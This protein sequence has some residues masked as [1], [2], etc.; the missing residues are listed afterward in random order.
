MTE[1]FKKLLF[2]NVFTEEFTELHFNAIKIASDSQTIKNP[3]PPLLK[4][5]GLRFKRNYRKNQ[6]EREKEIKAKK[7]R[8]KD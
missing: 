6:P 7:Q 4:K 3:L 1:T 8:N 5:K 2:H